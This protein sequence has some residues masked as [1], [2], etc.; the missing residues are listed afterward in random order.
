MNYIN[1]KVKM[2]KMK[3]LMQILYWSLKAK[4]DPKL[5]SICLKDNVQKQTVSE[6]STDDGKTKFSSNH[7]YIVKSAK[8]FYENIYTRRDNFKNC[9][10]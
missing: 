2:Q 10:F 7:N 3:N 8:K 9:H 5:T 1:W 6:L 4:N